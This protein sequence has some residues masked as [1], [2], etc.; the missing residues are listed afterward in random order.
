MI[1]VKD[2]EKLQENVIKLCAFAHKHNFL[3]LDNEAHSPIVREFVDIF[4]NGAAGPLIRSDLETLVR[5]IQAFVRL[6]VYTTDQAAAWLGVGIDTVRDAVWRSGELK[7][8]KPGHDRLIT[9]ASLVAYR[10]S[11]A[12]Q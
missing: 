7:S 8:M 6:P 2:I 11:Q 3:D 10:D 1:K 12:T 5:G 4:T 9:H